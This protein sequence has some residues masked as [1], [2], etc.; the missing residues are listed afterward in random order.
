MQTCFPGPS[1]EVIC[2]CA[3]SPGSGGRVKG[4]HQP[5][6]D[7]RSLETGGEKV[8]PLW[9]PTLEGCSSDLLRVPTGPLSSRVECPLHNLWLGH[10]DI[11]YPG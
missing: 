5:Y 4:L 7:L 9:G 3:D 1:G 10:E 8:S 11:S 2:G 6:R